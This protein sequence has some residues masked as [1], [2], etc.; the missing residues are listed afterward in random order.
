MTVAVPEGSPPPP[1]ETQQDP[2]PAPPPTGVT[3]LPAVERLTVVDVHPGDTIIATLRP[4]QYITD[5]DAQGLRARLGQ[6]F[7]GC[8]VVVL[9][10]IESIT[11]T[12]PAADTPDR[13][14]FDHNR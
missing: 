10:G 14:T 6:R 13:H 1:R 5:E 11:V 9:A 2:P 12:R 3:P 4:D 8:Q 7:P